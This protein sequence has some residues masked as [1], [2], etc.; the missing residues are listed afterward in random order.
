MYRAVPVHAELGCPENGPSTLL[1]IASKNPTGQLDFLKTLVMEVEFMD[2]LNV[3]G[4]IN[5]FVP[6]DAAW[7]KLIEDFGITLDALRDQPALVKRLLQY[8]TRLIFSCLL[9]LSHTRVVLSCS[10][11]ITPS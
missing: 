2:A 11:G 1:D 4:P 5:L 7:E 8:V 10:Q 3:P 9:R 6:I